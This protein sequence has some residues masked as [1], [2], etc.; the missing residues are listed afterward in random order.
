[1]GDSESEKLCA[2]LTESVGDRPADVFY[3]EFYLEKG[4]IFSQFYFK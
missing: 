3:Q 1:M 2:H 4:T